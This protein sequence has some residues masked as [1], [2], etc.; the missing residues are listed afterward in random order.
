MPE[1]DLTAIKYSQIITHVSWTWS[2]PH[3]LSLPLKI[4]CYWLQWAGQLLLVGMLKKSTVSPATWIIATEYLKKIYDP[5]KQRTQQLALMIFPLYASELIV[6]AN[7]QVTSV[8]FLSPWDC[9]LLR[10]SAEWWLSYRS[11]DT[12]YQ[13]IWDLLA[14]Y[15]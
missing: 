10:I 15:D 5:L 7:E 11:A 13:Y 8:F 9:L 3:T 2:A 4:D 6:C 1:L 14:C 12:T